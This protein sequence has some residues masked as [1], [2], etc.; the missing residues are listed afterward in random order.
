MRGP[1][2]D[3]LFLSH[4]IMTL[5]LTREYLRNGTNFKQKRK[6]CFN[7][8]GCHTFRQNLVNFGP[9]IGNT[10]AAAQTSD[11]SCPALLL[12]S[13]DLNMSNFGTARPLGFDQKWVLKTPQPPGTIIHQHVKFH[14]HRTMHIWVTDDLANFS[15]PFSGCLLH[16]EKSQGYTDWTVPRLGMTPANHRPFT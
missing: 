1:M 16:P 7:C 15:C 14:H 6:R 12:C 5:R 3:Y 2:A 9:Q 13:C 10:T 11:C 4:L 8:K